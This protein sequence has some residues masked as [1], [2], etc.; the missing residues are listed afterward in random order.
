MEAVNPNVDAEKGL[1]FYEWL[2][3]KQELMASPGPVLRGQ[4]MSE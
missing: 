3:G 4:V 1:K 2:A